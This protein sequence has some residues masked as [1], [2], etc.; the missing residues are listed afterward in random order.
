MSIDEVFGL[1]KILVHGFSELLHVD[2]QNGR[3]VLGSSMNVHYSSPDHFQ[4]TL[5]QNGQGQVQLTPFKMSI[6]VIAN[7]VQVPLPPNNVAEY[8][9]VTELLVGAVEHLLGAGHPNTADETRA[10]SLLLVQIYFVLFSHGLFDFLNPFSLKW[11]IIFRNVINLA[12]LGPVTGVL[13]IVCPMH[14]RYKN[15]K[16]QRVV[17]KKEGH[18]PVTLVSSA[19]TLEINPI[20]VFF[21]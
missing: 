16:C 7:P 2:D 4:C 15:R 3:E 17:L 18:S 19:L 13:H 12:L 21:R 1:N 6:E 10:K 9:I 20:H 8:V 14:T 5:A 11:R